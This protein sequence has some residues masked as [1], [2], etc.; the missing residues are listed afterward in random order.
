MSKTYVDME[1]LERLFKKYNIS[2]IDIFNE[3]KTVSANKAAGELSV[4]DLREVLDNKEEVFAIQIWQKED[5]KAAINA[6]NCKC[7]N[8]DEIIEKVMFH[9]KTFL[10]DCSDNW[11]KLYTVIKDCLT[12]RTNK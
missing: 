5:V 10:E 4:Y 1:E 6:M 11:D 2:Y 9:A 7:I 3:L 12:G 8:E